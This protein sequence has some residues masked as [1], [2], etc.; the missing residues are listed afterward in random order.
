MN[1]FDF[2]KRK[3]PA[4]ESLEEELERLEKEQGVPSKEEV[5]ARRSAANALRSA[6]AVYNYASLLFVRETQ[7][8][9][10]QFDSLPTTLKD[11]YIHRARNR[12]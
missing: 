7:G 1:F 9:R 3:K 8:T 12:S 4:V 6:G 10:E 2:F 11:T 5:L